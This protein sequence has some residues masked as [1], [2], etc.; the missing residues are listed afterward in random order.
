MSQPPVE[1]PLPPPYEPPSQQPTWAAPPPSGPPPSYAP[2]QFGPPGYPP[3]FPPPPRKRRVL[4][5]VL[6]SLAAV[7][8]L[9]TAVVVP[10]VL[11]R[12]DDE[13]GGGDGGSVDTTD[14]D[15]VESFDGLSNDHLTLGDTFDYPQS[16]PVGGQHAPVWL[17]CGVYDEPVPE[18]HVVHDLEHGTTWLTYRPDDLD[19]AGIEQL[20]DLL[21][22]NGILSPYPD[23][24][25]PVVITVW[26]RQLALTGAD[27]PRIPLFIAEF[28]A[29]ETAPEPYASCH[30][31]ADPDDLP[32]PGG[33]VI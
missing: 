18:V 12:D 31:G 11:T 23:Q 32:T 25:A 3:A 30:G 7:L 14:L 21:P 13:T 9:A 33:P 8:V 28:G 27:D 4:P 10:L 22:D 16:P 1:P 17:E 19:A 5:V 6:A 20:A 26:G 15:A 24:E 29:G 2:P